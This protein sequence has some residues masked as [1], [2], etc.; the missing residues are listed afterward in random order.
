MT[1]DWQAFLAVLASVGLVFLYALLR[2][3]KRWDDGLAETLKR[4]KRP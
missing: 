3:V 2:T 4:E 1:S